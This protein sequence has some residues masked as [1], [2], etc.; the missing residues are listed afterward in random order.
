MYLFKRLKSI[1]LSCSTDNST[2]CD[3]EHHIKN[4]MKKKLETILQ[5]N[6]F[7][8]LTEII[9]SNFSRSFI[10]LRIFKLF[11]STEKHS[12]YYNYGMKLIRV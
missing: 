9:L 8:Q 5:P 12:L 11:A 7:G 6:F 2:V 4:Y 3:T 1:Y 10:S